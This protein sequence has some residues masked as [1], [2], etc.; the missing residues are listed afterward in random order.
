[1]ADRARLLQG[2]RGGQE[3]LRRGDQEGLPQ[4]RAPVPPGPQRRRQAGRGALQGDL[5]GL[6]R[7]VGSREAQGVRPRHRPVRRVRRCPAA[8]IRARSA[9]ASATSSPTC[10]AVA[11]AQPAR[12]R[13]RRRGPR[14]T[15]REAARPRPRD[16][17]LADVRPGRQRRPGPACGADLAAVSDLPRHRRQ[18]RHHAEGLPGLQRPRGRVAEPGDLLDL[19]AVLELPRLRA[20]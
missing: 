15:R 18:A 5:A 16:R 7:A 3:R 6:R 20:P 17:G 14:R 9:A 10:S 13:A 12:R 11:A 19:P 2:P 4:A 8:S 1:M